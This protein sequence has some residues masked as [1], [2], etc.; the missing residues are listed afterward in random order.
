MFS[1]STKIQSSNKRGGFFHKFIAKFGKTDWVI[2]FITV[3]L[4]VFGGIMIRS[5]ELNRPVSDWT[6]HWILGGF[7]LIVA[8][9]ITRTNYQGL[10]RS[11]WYIYGANIALLA[12]VMVSGSSAKGAQRWIGIGG[13]VFQPSEFAKIA[14]IITLA[15]V[16]ER[17][18]VKY[19]S[20]FIKSLA[21]TLPPWFLVFIQPDLGSSLVFGVIAIG[22][23]YWAGANPGWLLL[24]TSP[25]V[26]AILFGVSMP[27]W[28]AWAILMAVIA[29]RTLPWPRACA[30]I[31]LGINIGSGFLGTV[32]WNVL[33]DYQKERLIMFLDPEK[34]ALGAGYHLIQSRIAIGAGGLW[35]QGIN[36]GT[37][38]QLNFIP[39]QHTDF[40]FSAI[41]EECGFWGSL[42][43]IATFWFLCWRI[44]RV[45]QTAKDN[46]GSLLVIGILSMLVFQVV[47]NIGMN[48][49]IAPVTGIPLPW[50]SYGRSALLKNF[51]SIGII[52][53]V[54]AARRSSRL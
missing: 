36:Q 53:S 19:L 22:M 34:D 9:L 6:Q 3:G 11:H 10:L 52:E 23:L 7:G 18:Q 51:I 28:I 41:G 50:I 2:L 29:W 35:G 24:L 47:V 17:R 12:A 20:E 13:F 42:L 49:G 33:K 48:V 38:T 30:A 14:L 25:L 4:T 26:A 37:Q 46:F 15:A 1:P 27:L 5:T 16:L 54:A 40:I 8:L 43:L 39:E 31:A 32:F 44:I 21:I 45:A